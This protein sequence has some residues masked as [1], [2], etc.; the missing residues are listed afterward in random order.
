MSDVVT[1]VLPRAGAADT[2]GA[3]TTTVKGESMRCIL[4]VTLVVLGS[5]AGAQ[6]ILPDIGCA[7]EDGLRSLKWDRPTH[8]TFENRRAVPMRAYWLNY[9]GKRVFYAEIAPGRRWTVQT[10]VTHPWVVTEGGNEYSGRC[11]FLY[12]PTLAPAVVIIR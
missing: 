11:H 7:Q 8:L 3:I 2:I 6:G 9:E 12:Q 4:I 10:F 1:A 5:P